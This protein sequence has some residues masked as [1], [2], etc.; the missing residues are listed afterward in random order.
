VRG[1]CLLPRCLRAARRTG[2]PSPRI[3]RAH[4]PRN[5]AATKTP[6]LRV[7]RSL[8]AEAVATAAPFLFQE[9]VRRDRSGPREYNDLRWRNGKNLA[10]LPV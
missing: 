1:R 10:T 6:L 5:H 8:G 2:C 7:L 9:L 4:S 3:A